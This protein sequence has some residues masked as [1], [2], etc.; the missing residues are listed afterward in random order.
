MTT[1]TTAN[2]SAADLGLVVGRRKASTPA[3][4]TALVSALRD[5]VRAWDALLGDDDRKDG[6]A[7]S[8]KARE[9]TRYAKVLIESHGADADGLKTLIVGRQILEV[10]DAAAL[11][12]LGIESKAPTT[13]RKRAQA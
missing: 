6:G 2:V 4:A 1:T 12:A 5:S 8:A 10:D 9:A 11:S 13:P 7:L 3:T